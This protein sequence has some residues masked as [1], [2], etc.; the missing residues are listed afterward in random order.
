M[1]CFRKYFGVRGLGDFLLVTSHPR[2]TL[3]YDDVVHSHTVRPCGWNKIT[4]PRFGSLR[5]SATPLA[6]STL[7]C[8]SLNAMA[9]EYIQNV[10]PGENED[11]I[12]QRHGLYKLTDL[13]FFRGL[14]SFLKNYLD[15]YLPCRKQYVEMRWEGH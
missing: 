13:E 14:V 9:S 15:E 12:R 11:H 7:A 3:E 8:F 1:A 10:L 6:S 4:M 5:P 2:Q